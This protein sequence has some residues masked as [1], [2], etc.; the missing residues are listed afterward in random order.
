M[1]FVEIPS[2]SSTLTNDNE[3]VFGALNSPLRNTHRMYKAFINSTCLNFNR[4][5]LVA[6]KF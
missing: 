2:K 5:T 4:G 6:V 3:V 1:S